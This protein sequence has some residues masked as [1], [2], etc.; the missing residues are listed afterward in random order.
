[1]FCSIIAQHCTKFCTV[2]L[3]FLLHKVLVSFAQSI[4]H[5]F[6]QLCCVQ[7]CFCI[8]H[9]C[10]F[11][12]HIFV[13]IYCTLNTMCKIV[14]FYCTCLFCVS[15]LL[16]CIDHSLVTLILVRCLTDFRGKNHGEIS[17]AWFHMSFSMGSKPQSV[18]KRISHG[19]HRPRISVA[20]PDKDFPWAPSPSDLRGWS[21]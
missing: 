14:W 2:L 13:Q 10:N 4:V 18:V 20:D 7:M 19:R 17:L 12:L 8:L 3:M 21:R 1:M 5:I 11:V 15:P 9:I 6:A 16:H